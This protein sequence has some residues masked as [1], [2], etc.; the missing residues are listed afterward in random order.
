MRMQHVLFGFLL[1]LGLA[2]IVAAQTPCAGYEKAS[3]VYTEGKLDEALQ[4]YKSCLDVAPGD[5]KLNF[6]VGLI[7]ENKGDFENATKY[8]SRAVAL[9]PF[10]QEFLRDRFD[11]KVPGISRGLI[12]DHFGQKFCYGFLFMSSDKISYRSLWGFPRLGTDDSFETPIS[13]IARVEV[14]GKERG[15]GWISN[16]P[17]RLELHFFFKEDIKGAVDSWHRDEMKFFFGQTQITQTDLMS[18]ARRII[19]YLKARGVT[20]KEE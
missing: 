4:G 14:K 6:M 8:W 5:A 2:A 7:Y 13:N 18:F 11:A 17:Q 3:Q 16:M 12:H 1:F 9:D 10:Y 19:E 20:I 15:K